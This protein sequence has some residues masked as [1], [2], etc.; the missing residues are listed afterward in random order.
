[1]YEITFGETFDVVVVTVCWW[2]SDYDARP[3]S[4]RPGMDSQMRHERFNPL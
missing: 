4:E 1:M 3:D 2:S